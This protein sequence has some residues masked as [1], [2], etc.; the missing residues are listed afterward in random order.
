MNRD[1]KPMTFQYLTITTF[2]RTKDVIEQICQEA[3]QMRLAKDR[4]KT[5]IYV[6]NQY[7][8]AWIR[9][10]SRP[11]RPM[12]S[13]ILDSTLARDIIDDGRTF[14]ASKDWYTARG[15]PYLVFSAS[16]L[17]VNRTV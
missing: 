4:N 16:F 11:P 8:Y 14:L 2:G 7:G 3:M 17:L 9:A 12:D 5:T 13:V 15:I 10:L 1:K 6:L